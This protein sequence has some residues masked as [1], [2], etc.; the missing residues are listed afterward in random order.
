MKPVL[1]LQHLSADGPAYLLTW[2]HRHAMPYVV[3]N[4][5]A[6]RLIPR[7]HEQLCG[8]GHPGRRDECQRSAALT[9]A[10]ERLIIDAMARKRPVIGHCLGG[11]LMARALGARVGPSIA[12]EIGWQTPSINAG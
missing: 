9:A 7:R 11:Q 10:R 3:L 2:L 5:Q 1:I 4:T 8:A 6:R 12:R